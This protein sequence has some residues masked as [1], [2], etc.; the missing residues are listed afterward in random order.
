MQG[1]LIVV[2]VFRRA[3]GRSIY[4]SDHAHVADYQDID[5]QAV[6]AVSAAGA[7]SLPTVYDRIR[8]YLC[9]PFIA[10]TDAING[11]FNCR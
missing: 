9:S 6:S 7:A 10:I 3:S 8:C 11:A 1:V 2:V 4:A 5:S